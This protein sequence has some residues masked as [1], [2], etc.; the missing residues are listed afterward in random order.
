MSESKKLNL[1]ALKKTKESPQT[2]DLEK[3][4]IIEISE[5]NTK[6]KP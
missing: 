3:K 5:E 1:K 2:D 6:E 4:E